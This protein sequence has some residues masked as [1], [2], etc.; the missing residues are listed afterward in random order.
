MIADTV[1][2]RQQGVRMKLSNNKGAI[3]LG[4]FFLAGIS[5]LFIGALAVPFVL[6]QESNMHE[7]VAQIDA[8]SIATEVELF[9]QSNKNI[10][11]DQPIT[12]SYNSAKN[13]L[14]IDVPEFDLELKSLNLSLSEGSVLPTSSS[15][16]MLNSNL[17]LSASEYCITVNILGRNA[18]HNQNG[19]TDGCY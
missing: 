13:S 5:A 6:A 15:G 11:I 1:L 8:R 10:P 16:E 18:F 9:I 17:I 4:D 19:P 14:L 2:A 7:K 12:I 3:S